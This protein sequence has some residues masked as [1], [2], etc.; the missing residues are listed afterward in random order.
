MHSETLDS[1][2]GIAGDTAVV[3]GAGTAGVPA[4]MGA[5]IAFE[6][7]F[8]VRPTETGRVQEIVAWANRTATPLVPISSG[9]PHLH[10]GSAPSVPGAV[11]VD[12]SGMTRIPRIDR[13][14]RLALI[15]AGVTFGQLIPGL[16]AA[17]LRMAIPL[18]PRRNKSVLASLLE[19]EPTLVP[20]WHWNMMEPLRTLEIIWGNGD[21]LVSGSQTTTDRDEDWDT[22]II[23]MVGGGPAQVD[24][25]RMMSGA[26][27]SMGIATWASIKVEPISDDQQLLFIPAPELGDLIDCAYSLLRVR[28]GDETFL[29]NAVTLAS[30]LV[31]EP[32]ERV[33]L[34]ADLP[35]WCLVVAIGGGS[36]LGAEKVA[37]RAADI[38][39]IVRAHG[40]QIAP[41]LPGCTGAHML[42][43]LQNPPDGPYW[44]EN[45]STASKDLFFMSTLDRTPAFVATMEAVAAKAGGSSAGFG[46]YIQPV[47]MGADTHCEFILPYDP[48]DPGDTNRAEALFEEASRVLFRAG[49]YYSRPYGM[50]SDMVQRGRGDHRGDPEDQ[51]DLRSQPR[52]E[53]RQA[54]LL[55]C[56]T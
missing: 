31:R 49:A 50:W 52:H 9:G 24:F 10:G 40:L 16:R 39:D 2:R 15:E 22:G 32:A 28:F 23:P 45:P 43:L 26:Q 42:D 19:R 12:L 27:G 6:P 35:P 20:R 3:E 34:A 30:L 41:E 4:R 29:A 37:A 44:R 53:P 33:R 48:A 17:G 13:R 8:T 46:V 38:A 36:I 21:H 14:Q 7:R 18:L 55:A 51:A 47:H 5:G 1:L 11:R 56:T 25:F 54:L